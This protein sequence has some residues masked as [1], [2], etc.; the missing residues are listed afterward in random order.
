MDIK[1]QQ[2]CQ[3]SIRRIEQLLNCGIFNQVHFKHPLQKSAF[4]ELMICLRDLLHKAK[5]YATPISFADDV[6]QNKY[7]S[8][9]TSAV[10]AVRDACCHIDSFKRD[11]EGQWGRMSYNVV[12]GKGGVMTLPS[13]GVALRSDYE[14]DIAY[15]FG[16]NRLYMKR[17]IIRA[18]QEAR[19]VLEPLLRRNQ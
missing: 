14:D 7:V 19:S 1:A 8:D 16:H 3:E 4:I 2:E 9:I 18:F 17:H 13:E 5:K 6:L 11:F 12:Y 10:T 15:F